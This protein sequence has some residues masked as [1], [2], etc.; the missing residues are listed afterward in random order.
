MVELNQMGNYAKVSA[1]TNMRINN[2]ER[3]EQ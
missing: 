1:D 2:C 3:Q